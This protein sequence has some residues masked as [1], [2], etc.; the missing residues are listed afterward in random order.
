MSAYRRAARLAALCAITGTS[1]FCQA[2]PVEFPIQ[3]IPG[4]QAV[5][6]K[7]ITDYPRAVDA[8]L[9]VLVEKFNLPPPRGK[10]EIH[11]TRESYEQ[12]L[13][14]YLKLKPALARSTA[15][16]SRAAVGSNTLLVNEQAVVDFTWPQ[17]I[18]EMAHELTHILQLTLANRPGING[19]QWLIEGFAEWMG[20]T[21]MDALGLDNL[22]VVRA[23]FADKVRDLKRNGALPSL[24]RLDSFA[25]WV[26]ARRKSSFDATYTQSF[27]VT[28]FLI[29]RHTLAAVVEYFRRYDK[30]DDHQANFKAVFGEDLDEFGLALD[31]HFERLLH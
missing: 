4:A 19:N 2:A 5:D 11:A 7:E 25:D 12:A 17:R 26:E 18:E 22:A 15:Q 16:F 8:V 20:F 31:Q 23:R 13:I 29:Q 14:K 6:A 3:R 9:R 27:L 10:V 30:S 24:L 1:F 21:V 28:D